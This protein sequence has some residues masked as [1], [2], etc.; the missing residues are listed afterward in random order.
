MVDT[1]VEKH[2]YSTSTLIP[3]YTGNIVQN[4]G[5]KGD[6]GMI[7][8][9]DLYDDGWKTDNGLGN[10]FLSHQFLS[11]LLVSRSI[12]QSVRAQTVTCVCQPVQLFTSVSY[13][14]PVNVDTFLYYCIIILT[15]L[16]HKLL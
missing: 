11:G 9:P 3:E 15:R 14:L 1:M 7:T 4:G 12:K 6:A 8:P 2:C 5:T 16:Y 10:T 13:S